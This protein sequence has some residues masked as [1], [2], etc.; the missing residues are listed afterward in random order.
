MGSERESVNDSIA[1][2][3]SSF[4]AN[5]VVQHFHAAPDAKLYEVL[6]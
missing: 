4:R 2:I 5:P 6:V 3:P 1:G